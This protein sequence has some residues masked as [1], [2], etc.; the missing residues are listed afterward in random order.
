MRPGSPGMRG[1][2]PQEP[3]A[4]ESAGSEKSGRPF[5]SPLQSCPSPW[6]GGNVWQGPERPLC[7]VL[8]GRLENAVGKLM[9]QNTGFQVPN[10]FWDW[11]KR[12]FSGSCHYK[13]QAEL[14][15]RLAGSRASTSIY[16]AEDSW[17]VPIGS[18]GSRA[19]LCTNH[20]DWRRT[21]RFDWPRFSERR[22]VIPTGT[23]WITPGEGEDATKRN[24]HE[25]LRRWGLEVLGRCVWTLGWK[26]GD[27]VPV[28]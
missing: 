16:S 1:K 9:T 18:A 14:A 12:D 5:P 25:S 15:S 20:S 28:G 27:S 22:F 7:P 11:L 26:A 10:M 4:S 21:G 13:V 23:T 17:P 24:G 3:T 2:K 19:C 8:L 6:S